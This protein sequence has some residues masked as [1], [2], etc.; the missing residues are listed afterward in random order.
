M[1]ILKIRDTSQ[2]KKKNLKRFF[3]YRIQRRDSMESNRLFDSVVAST[4]RNPT[5]LD[6]DDDQLFSDVDPMIV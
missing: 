4:A 5:K 6:A 1:R 3:I 2:K